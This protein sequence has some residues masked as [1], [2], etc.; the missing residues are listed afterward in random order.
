MKLFPYFQITSNYQQVVIVIALDQSVMVWYLRDLTTPFITVIR[1]CRQITF[2]TLNIFWI[3]STKPYC[4]YNF[5]QHYLKKKIFAT[6]FPLLMDSPLK[7]PTPNSQNL[8]SMT[9]CIINSTVSTWNNFQTVYHGHNLLNMSPK[10]RNHS[11]IS[12]YFFD[13]Y[14]E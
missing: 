9:K 13:N 12:K 2:V 11:L 7:I 3:L 1:D 14:E 5:I 8:L 6:N 10:I 4:P